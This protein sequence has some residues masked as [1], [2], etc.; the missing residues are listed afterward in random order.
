MLQGGISSK[1]RVDVSLKYRYS[2]LYIQNVTKRVRNCRAYFI[3][4]PN[5]D[6]FHAKIGTK[7]LRNG[8]RRGLVCGAVPVM[9]ELISSSNLEW[10]LH[11]LI[12]FGTYRE[13]NPGFST[14]K[15]E[16]KGLHF[17]SCRCSRVFCSYLIE[18]GF[19]FLIKIGTKSV[20]SASEMES[21]YGMVCIVNASA[22]HF[23]DKIGMKIDGSMWGDGKCNTKIGEESIMQISSDMFW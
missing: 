9:R 4:R 2:A 8:A 10:N 6:D 20:V 13:Q 3:A 14:P 23:K 7:K 15:M 11:F 17:R 5:P 21:K 1:Q 19:D 16:G 22:L 12:K 18:S